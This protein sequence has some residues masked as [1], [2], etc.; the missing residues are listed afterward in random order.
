MDEDQILEDDLIELTD[1]EIVS[2]S[3]EAV[4][5]THGK[6]KWNEEIEFENFKK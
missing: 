3:K 4:Q 6:N 1:K 5:A 2:I